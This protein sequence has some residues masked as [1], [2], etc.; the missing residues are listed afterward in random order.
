MQTLNLHATLRAFIETLN[1]GP[2][3]AGYAFVLG[4]VMLLLAFWLVLWAS[5]RVSIAEGVHD[6]GRAQ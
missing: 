4:L 2:V 1:P 3:L 6:R 5:Y